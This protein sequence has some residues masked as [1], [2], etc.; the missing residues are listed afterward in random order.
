MGHAGC[1]EA[2]I[3]SNPSP[4]LVNLISTEF[5]VKPDTP[6]CFLWHTFEDGG[7]KAENSIEFALALKKVNVPFELHVYEKGGHGLGLGSGEYNP[8]KWLPWTYECS[9]WLKEQGFGR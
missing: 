8:A 2:L 1:K 7:V 5:Q 6:P 4:D 9:R 3:G